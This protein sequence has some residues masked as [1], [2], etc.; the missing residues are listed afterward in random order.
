M[1][2]NNSKTRT[3]I[4]QFDEILKYLNK[5]SIDAGTGKLERTPLD[6]NN[7]LDL[8][9]IHEIQ[10]GLLKKGIK[11]DA[12]EL[13][14]MIFHLSMNEKYILEDKKIYGG[15]IDN[16]PSFRIIFEGKLFIENGGYLRQRKDISIQ[17]FLRVG[18]KFIIILGAIG[19]FGYFILEYWKNFYPC[20]CH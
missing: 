15:V 8:Q 3:S 7:R 20:L 1:L 9:S 13:N 6:D 14:Q 5:L 17:R 19:A 18:E 2:I 16:I 10:Q 4:N 11:I 12:Y